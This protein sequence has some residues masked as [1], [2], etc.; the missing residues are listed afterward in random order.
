MREFRG[1]I[2]IGE[3]AQPQPVT[4]QKAQI[5]ES[6]DRG[7]NIGDCAG[8]RLQ[9]QPSADGGSGQGQ[10]RIGKVRCNA[11]IHGPLGADQ[12]QLAGHQSR[13]GGGSHALELRHPEKLQKGEMHHH[14]ESDG[15]PPAAQAHNHQTEQAY[16]KPADQ[17]FL[18]RSPTFA[19]AFS[20]CDVC[21]HRPDPKA[22]RPE[23]SP[24]RAPDRATAGVAGRAKHSVAHPSAL[25]ERAEAR[26]GDKGRSARPQ[27]DRCSGPQADG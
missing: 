18:I 16:E 24:Y 13:L 4:G 26:R 6:E 27:C 23:H 2:H 19:G 11:S 7:G 25:P 9:Q 15:E 1:E 21:N 20:G 5:E 17:T 8:D 10:H 14:A 3:V 12:Q 22:L